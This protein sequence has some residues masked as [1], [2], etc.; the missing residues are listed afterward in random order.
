MDRLPSDDNIGSELVDNILGKVY[1]LVVNFAAVFSFCFCMYVVQ[2]D[3]IQSCVTSIAD[4]SP[5]PRKRLIFGVQD[6]PTVESS[7]DNFVNI[8][9]YES[10][11]DFLDGDKKSPGEEMI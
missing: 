9:K 4:S 11:I 8:S 1:A 7:R 10:V 2:S 3:S 5:Y 6:D